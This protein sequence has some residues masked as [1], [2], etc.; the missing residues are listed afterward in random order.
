MRNRGERLRTPHSRAGA[1]HTARRDVPNAHEETPRL[2]CLPGLP[3]LLTRALRPRTWKHPPSGRS[4]SDER[5]PAE[6]MGRARE[7]VRTHF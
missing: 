1:S 3:R 5:R 6:R 4:V 7:C 2:G